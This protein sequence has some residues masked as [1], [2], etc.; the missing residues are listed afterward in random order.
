MHRG[1]LL[2]SLFRTVPAAAVVLLVAGAADAQVHDHLQCYSV[3]DPQ[4]RV[5]YTAKLD[6]LV[7][8]PGCLIRTPAKMICVP[9]AKTDIIPSP[10]GGG[11]TGIPNAF[12]C[13]KMR[14]RNL[15]LPTFQLNDQ[16]GNRPVTVR[17]TSLVCAPVAPPPPPSSTTLATT[18][19][20]PCTPTTCAAAGATCGPLADGCGGTLDCGSCTA[21]QTCGGGGVA[22]ACGCTPA[23]CAQGACGI[24]DDGCGGTI[25]CGLCCGNHRIDPGEVC[26]PPSFCGVDGCP[27]ACNS[28]GCPQG[29][30][31]S[32]QC[33]AC[34]PAPRC[35]NCAPQPGD[36]CDATFGVNGDNCAPGSRCNVSGDGSCQCSCAG[37]GQS[38]LFGT[39]CCSAADV[40]NA[41]V[42]C[43]PRTCADVTPS[44]GQLSDGCGG[45]IDCGACP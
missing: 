29:S 1:R 33:D 39:H 16:F 21:P 14:C 26:D 3:R 45:T 41:F 42:C 9:A 10:P 24:V 19:T 7:V 37:T 30:T 35:Q 28:P 23:T 25:D 4:A 13:Y 8:E 2:P 15:G 18:T 36:A 38:C 17:K 12:G 6:G 11:G 43:R 31:C 40:C 20:V 22:H 27:A 34:V 32:F 5:T 44:C